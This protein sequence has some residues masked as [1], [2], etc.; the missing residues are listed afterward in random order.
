FASE[1]DLKIPP[2]DQVQF[3]V[4]GSNVGGVLLLYMGLGVCVLGM[5]FGWFQYTQTK[6]LPVHS[7]MKEVSNL[8]WETCKTY[9]FQQGKFLSGLWILIAVCMGYYFGVLQGMPVNH[10]ILIL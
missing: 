6:A 2:L 5:L 8:I 9:L 10:V 7:S 3:N 1:A 4:Q